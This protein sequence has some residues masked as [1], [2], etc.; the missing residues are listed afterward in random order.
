MNLCLVM[1]CWKEERICTCRFFTFL[2]TVTVMDPKSL[3]K[4]STSLPQSIF[5]Y[6][7]TSS[8][9]ECCADCFPYFNIFLRSFM[10]KLKEKN[11]YL[12]SHWSLEGVRWS[13]AHPTVNDNSVN[14]LP[15]SVKL[16]VSDS[17]WVLYSSLFPV[18]TCT[19]PGRRKS[20]SINFLCGSEI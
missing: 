6:C 20:S 12:A 16:A 4:Q 1:T 15:D 13:N 14:C 10:L 2:V 17:C 9:S 3:L 19:A 18:Q 11:R 7:P 5:L 8:F